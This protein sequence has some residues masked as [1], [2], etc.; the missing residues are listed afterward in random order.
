MNEA[1]KEMID[2]AREGFRTGS[3]NETAFG[4]AA[5]KAYE[6]D[7]DKDPY[8]RKASFAKKRRREL[9]NQQQAAFTAAMAK[10]VADGLSGATTISGDDQHRFANVTTKSSDPATPSVWQRVIKRL[11]KG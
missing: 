8:V 11:R 1:L 2:H 10:S 3:I 5:D 4:P 7:D 6:E 9:L